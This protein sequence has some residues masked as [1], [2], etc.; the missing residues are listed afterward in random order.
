MHLTPPMMDLLLINTNILLTKE[1]LDFHP[2]ESVAITM[3]S[4]LLKNRTALVMDRLP[5]FLQ[6]FR[7]ILRNV[8]KH[9]NSD[10]N[11]NELEV[12][13]ITNCA[14]KLEKLTRNLVGY[15]K[16]MGRIAMYLIAD[17]LQQ[18]EQITL[19]PTVKVSTVE[20]KKLMLLFLII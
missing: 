2:V 10:L 1:P 8:C 13:D 4:N 19:Y 5:P 9:G 18:Y 14:H 3:L 6:Q 17:I 20:S 16:D 12:R 7:L 15:P 11:L